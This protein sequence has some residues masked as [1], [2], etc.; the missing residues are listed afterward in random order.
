MFSMLDGLQLMLT[1]IG[2]AIRLRAALDRN[3]KNYWEQKQ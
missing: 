3:A 1:H 2:Q